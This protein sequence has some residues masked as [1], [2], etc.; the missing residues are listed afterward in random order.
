[1]LPPVLELYVLWHP[2]DH[3]GSNIA[4][5]F[6]EHFHGTAFTGL[7][8]SAVDVYVRS[9][10]WQTLNGVPRPIS[11]DKSPLPH[12]IALAEF[13]AIVPLMGNE[14]AA[15]MESTES[16][17]WHDYVE[18]IVGLKADSPEK[19][20][21]FPYLMDKGAT[22]NTKLGSLL[23]EYQQ[24]AS[25]PISD[26]GES[27][28]SRMCRDLTQG[29]AQ[30]LSTEAEK[31]LTVFISHTKQSAPG[32]EDDTA[33]LVS[34]VRNVI[35]D[36]R[37]NEFFDA[38][39]IQ[40]GEDWDRE[41]RE[42][43]SAS[44]LLC[45]RS[46]LYTSREWCQREVL[47]A[48]RNG[49]PVVIIDALCNGEDRG[50]F[51]MDHVPRIPARKEHGNWNE[52]DIYRALGLLVDESFKRVLWMHQEVLARKHLK[53]DV[54]WWATHAPEPL[55]LV[56]WLQDS[57]LPVDGQDVRIIHPDPPLGADEKFVLGQILQL[58]GSEAKLDII[59]PSLLAA[60]GG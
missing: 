2:G 30:L 44:A 51:L 12:G 50:S 25:G 56:Q 41:L 27:E 22:D 21:I 28:K 32:S 7:I 3:N 9:H 58:C 38:S 23:S 18:T 31:R 60:R 19:V 40:V 11:S 6:V 54:S 43:S 45:I 46:D 16:T 8:A 13:T 29:L 36:T 15:A 4:E 57:T 52:N 39:D 53:H 34:M 47:I 59:T 5:M 55:T 48:K 42:K 49:M 17:P 20:G 1:M 24:I 10:G 37:L 26:D 35:A 33:Q 14:M